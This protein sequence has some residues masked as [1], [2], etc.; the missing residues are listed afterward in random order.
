MSAPLILVLAGGTGG[1]VYPAL[2][3]AQ[4]LSDRGYRVEWVGTQRGLEARVVPAAGFVLHAL[5]VRGLRGKSP[6]D[7]LRG[8]FALCVSLFM[9]LWLVQRTSPACVLGMGGYASG[10]AA[11][12]ARLLRRPLVLHEQNAVAGTTNRLLARMASARL[13][14][15]PGAFPE[16]RPG[17]FVGNPVRREMLQSARSQQWYF[18]GAR[19]LRLL[20]LGGSLGA[21]AINEVLPDMLLAMRADGTDPLPMVW[22]QC[23]DAHADSMKQIYADAGLDDVRCEPFIED[24]ATA[25]AWADLVLCRAGALTIAELAVMARPALLVPLPQAIDDHQRRNALYLTDRGAAL[26]LPQSSLNAQL[27]AEEIRT[28]AGDPERLALMSRQAAGC[29]MP[30]ATDAVADCCEGYLE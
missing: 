18:D 22:H 23:G 20:V 16:R 26:L 14:G 10:P 9:A 11:L 3:V 8:L 25:Y 5:P 1:H 24:M 15:F 6:L 13:E 17:E 21:R 2:A 12:A 29:A 19:P 27:L 28:L 30:L 7:S 4:A